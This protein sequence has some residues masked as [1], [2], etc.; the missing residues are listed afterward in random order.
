MTYSIGKTCTFHFLNLEHQNTS[1]YFTREFEG[2]KNIF[3]SGGE[4]ACFEENLN[5]G[6]K[7]LNGDP[8]ITH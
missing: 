3:F 4:T 2:K 6:T 7:N 8:P 1:G 5:E